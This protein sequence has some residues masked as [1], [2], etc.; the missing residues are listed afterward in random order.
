MVESGKI[1]AMAMYRSIVIDNNDNQINKGQ[2]L[3]CE[4][5]LQSGN[6]FM[7]SGGLFQQARSFIPGD[8][9]TITASAIMEQSDIFNAISIIGGTV[10]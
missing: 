9:I 6:V 7:T 1:K 10:V 4:I 5:Q 3:V 2:D 8:E